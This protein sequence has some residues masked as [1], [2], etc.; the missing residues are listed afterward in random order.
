MSLSERLSWLQIRGCM[1]C[2]S[3]RGKIWRAHVNG[4]GRYWAEENAPGKAMESAV[5]LWKSNGMLMDGYADSIKKE[6]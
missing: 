4:A 2:L 1:P 3:L 6:A 5:R